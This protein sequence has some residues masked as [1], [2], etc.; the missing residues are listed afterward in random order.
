[1]PTTN[2]TTSRPRVGGDLCARH[3]PR[4]AACR[5]VDHRDEGI[6]VIST[7]PSVPPL[8]PV[9]SKSGR[10]SGRARC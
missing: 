5:V 6:A 3:G 2:N 4:F 1:M 10:G 8:V 9:V 7:G